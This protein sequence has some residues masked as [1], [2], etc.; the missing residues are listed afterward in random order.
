MLK[1]SDFGF[2]KL[3]FGDLKTPVYTPYYVAGEACGVYVHVECWITCH[4]M[5]LQLLY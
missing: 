1:L 2:A 4:I 5:T 3:D